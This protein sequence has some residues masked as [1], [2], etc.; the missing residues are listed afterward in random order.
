MI[1]SGEGAISQGGTAHGLGGGSAR[2]PWP[3]NYAH[4]HRGDYG[5]IWWFNGA[6][7]DE[8]EGSLIALTHR[9]TPEWAATAERGVLVAWAVQ[10]LAW[11]DNWLLIYDN[12]EDPDDLSPYLGA[13]HCGHHLAT[14]RRA[15]GWP[16]AVATWPLSS[17]DPDDATDLLLQLV[18]KNTAPTVREELDART[19]VTVLGDLHP[20]TLHSRNNLAAAY[21]AAGDFDRASALLERTVTHSVAVLGE[22][23]PRTAGVRGNLSSAREA[24]LGM[25]G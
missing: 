9:L 12:V 4:R 1:S 2:A 23:H 13:L 6:S 21:Q 24:A 17:L 16:D 3:C 7:P 18:S 20:D 11:H 22:A 14:D 25:R 10:W 19:L 5:L 15:T 8:I